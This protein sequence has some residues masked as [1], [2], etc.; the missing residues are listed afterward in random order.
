METIHAA[1]VACSSSALVQIAGLRTIGA[2]LKCG[3]LRVSAVLD[4]DNLLLKAMA[5]HPDDA[6]VQY[7]ACKLL[8]LVQQHATMF[9]QCMASKNHS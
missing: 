1:L 6:F 3:A 5:N 8:R 4:I 2:M 7:H 9:S